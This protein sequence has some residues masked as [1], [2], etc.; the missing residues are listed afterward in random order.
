MSRPVASAAAAVAA[1]AAAAPALSSAS[2]PGPRRGVGA[3]LRLLQ[4]LQGHGLPWMR[5]VTSREQ[6]RQAMAYFATRLGLDLAAIPPVI[7]IA[8]TK[9]KGS[10]AAFAE[11]IL[12]HKGLRT[13]ESM[14]GRGGE[15]SAP[16]TCPG[17]LVCGPAALCLPTMKQP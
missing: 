14:G 5:T 2:S 4:R 8:G 12:R 9:G 10:T 7:H 13:G 3:T 15:G 16:G 1:A 11:S 17:R 6:V